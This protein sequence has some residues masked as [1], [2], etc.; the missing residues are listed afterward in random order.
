MRK[1]LAVVYFLLP[2]LWLVTGVT[3]APG[4]RSA[5]SSGAKGADPGG[6]DPTAGYHKIWEARLP[7][8]GEQIS[9]PSL[10][11]RS[12]DTYRVQVTGVLDT[13]TLGAKYDAELRSISAREFRVR[14]DHLRFGSPSWVSVYAHHQDHRYVYRLCPKAAKRPG[15]LC[16]S[17]EGIPYQ[18]RV[19]PA[20]LKRE[21]SSTLRVSLWK[22]GPAPQARGAIRWDFA[23]LFAGLALVAAL[24]VW[25]VRRKRPRPAD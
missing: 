18:F 8:T 4:A 2:T 1:L 19:S 6:A 22:K 5:S 14:H 12:A 11:W 20:R 21:S 15:R 9:S 24:I 7:I 13:G 25:W 17:L 10:R 3:A 16:L 23:G